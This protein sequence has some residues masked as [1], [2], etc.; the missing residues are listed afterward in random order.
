VTKLAAEQL[1]LGYAARLDAVLTVIVLRYF[2]VYGPGQRP[3]MLIERAIRSRL[4]G[5]PLQ[6]HGDGSHR[7]D[8]VY[9]GDVVR[10]NLLAA[11]APAGSQVVNIGSGTNASVNQ[12]LDMIG[13]LTGGPVDASYRERRSGDV[14]TTHADISRA[15]QILGYRPSTD[16]RSG[17]AAQISGQP[18]TGTAAD[19]IRAGC[20]PG[21]GNRPQ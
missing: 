5:T 7:R 17:L 12:V 9:V 14:R 10:A 4:R 11:S 2:T 20:S 16:L 19:L 13:E 21:N 1:A 3:D 6:I 18:A 8:F 15:G